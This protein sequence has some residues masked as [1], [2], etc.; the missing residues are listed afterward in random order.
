MAD[1]R[2]SRSTRRLLSLPE[3]ASY[4]G[5]STWTVRELTW[6]GR[7]PVVRIT[8]KLL[9]DLQDLDALIDQEKA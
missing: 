8:R 9:F 3:A 1:P 7:L 5:L 6:K 4:L 2:S